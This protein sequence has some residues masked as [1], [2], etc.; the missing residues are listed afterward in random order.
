MQPSNDPLLQ[1]LTREGV[2]INVSV[3]FW[4]G[5]KKL[6]AEDLGLNPDD[7]SDRLISLGHKRLLPKDALSDLALVEGRAHALIETNTF[8]FLNGLAHF[9]PNAKLEEVTGKLDQLGIEFWQAKGKFL[10]GY[11]RHQ[12]EAAREWRQVAER[13][14]VDPDHLVATIEAA[15]P[16][17]AKM[18]KHFGFDVSLFQIAVPERL[19]TDLVTLAD[20]R[21]VIEARQQAAREAGAK[22]RNDA[23]QFVAECVA[24]LREQTALLCEEMLGS[25][26]SGKTDGVHQKTLNRLARFIDQFKQMNFTNDTVME[27]Q[28]EQVR[29]Q[30]LGRT[31]EEYRD[32]KRA[33]GQLVGGLEALRDKARELAQADA[34]AL[35][36][37]FGQLGRRKFHLAA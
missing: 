29:Q 26:G 5:S 36:A 33:Q 1:A 30:F 18:D 19:E 6:K 20:Q 24:T 12:E 4:R 3:R 25:I 23:E 27:Q 16:N 22:I 32:N 14:N 31:A 9:V 8:P 37:Q 2:L 15:F 13:L 34:T 21:Q 10:Q 11:S 28:L 17:P 35:V 7:V